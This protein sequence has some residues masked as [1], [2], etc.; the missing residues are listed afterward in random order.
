M[1]RPVT[2]Q[3]PVRGV[4]ARCR[5]CRCVVVVHHGDVQSIAVSA[6]GTLYDLESSGQLYSRTWAAGE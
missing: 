5:Q 6:D 1:S 3:S 4:S 2:F